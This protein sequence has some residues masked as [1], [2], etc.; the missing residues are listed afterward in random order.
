MLPTVKNSYSSDQVRIK[1]RKVRGGTM[2][3][4]RDLSTGAAALLGAG[5]LPRAAQ[6]AAP[7]RLPVTV[8][9]GNMPTIQVTIEGKGPYTFLIDTGAT[10]SAVT[11][12]IAKDIKLNWS[13]RRVRLSSIKGDTFNPVCSAKEIV[14]GGSIRMPAWEMAALDAPPMPGVDGILPASILTALPC[15][16]DYEAGELRYY[17][18]GVMDLSGFT[19]IDAFFHAEPDSVEQVFVPMRMGGDKLVCCMDTGASGPVYLYSDTVKTHKLWDK[20]PVLSEGDNAGANGRVVKARVVMATDVNIG[21]VGAA[22]LPVILGDP[23]DILATAGKYHE[24]LLGATFLSG[25]TLAF[26]ADKSVYVKR[27]G[28]N[29]PVL[30]GVKVGS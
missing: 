3:T 16:L 17:M 10:M 18:D 12:A 21:G 8:T 23:T 28:R 15:Q 13:P 11:E 6:A 20:Y 4:R 30:A 29:L 27:N 26:A 24:G 5:L 2:I 14:M 9:S 19:K 25:F 22:Q 1:R 7:K